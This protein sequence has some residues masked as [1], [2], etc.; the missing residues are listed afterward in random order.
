MACV[1][2]RVCVFIQSTSLCP[3]LGFNDGNSIDLFNVCTGC[4]CAQ[5]LGQEGTS[6]HMLQITDAIMPE[7][8][9]IRFS[10][11]VIQQLELCLCQ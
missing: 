9:M 6:L 2:V 3:T 7:N 4:T 8:L 10:I 11:C 1:R 5:F